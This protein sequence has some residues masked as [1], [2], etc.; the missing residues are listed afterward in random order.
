M[1]GSWYF[2]SAP[3]FGRHT[4]GEIGGPDGYL[5]RASTFAGNSMFGSWQGD[6]F[7]V[8]SYGTMIASWNR[9][10]GEKIISDRY[11]SQTTSH[12]QG[13][14]RAWLAHAARPEPAPGK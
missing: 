13:L 6:L 10:T 4:Y 12:H 1:Y 5:A 2:A 8:Y 7:V 3:R 11:Y 9:K 14:C